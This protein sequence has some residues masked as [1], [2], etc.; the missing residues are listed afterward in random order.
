M[1]FSSISFIFMFLPAVIFAYFACPKR[2]LGARNLILLIFS[3]AFYFYGEPKFIIVMICSILLNYFFGLIIHIRQSTEKS[4]KVW[5]CISVII[6]LA[7]LFYFKYLSFAAENINIIFGGNLQF[8]KIIMPIGI[9]FFTFQAMSYVF[10][11]YKKTA[12]VQ[13][14]PVNMA[15]YISMFPQL[16]AGPVVRY[17]TVAAE[18]KHRTTTVE[19]FSHGIIRFIYGLSKKMIIANSMGFIADQV[20]GTRTHSLASATAWLGAAAYAF[21]IYYDFSGYSDM[22]IGLGKIFGFTFL[23]NFTFPYISKSITEFWRRWHISLSTWFRD[24]VYIPLG[25]NRVS[26]PRHILN[27]LIV[28]FLTGL[29]HGAAWNF[30]VWGLYFAVILI[31]EKTFI[32]KWLEKIWWPVSHFYAVILIIIGWIIFRSDD[33]NYA[34]GY[35]ARMFNLPSLFTQNGQAYYFLRQYWAEWLLAVVFSFPAGNFVT[36]IIGRHKDKAVCY[37]IRFCYIF[38]I[39]SVS[40]L[41]IVNSTFNPF[42]YFRF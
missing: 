29:W 6:N 40:V 11:V 35:I 22:A 7:I 17:E 33:L 32:L 8:E 30:I 25:G 2:F 19:K 20:F 13:K 9:S 26:F 15:L 28:W 31:L 34:L 12:S 18:I 24:Y 39:F 14:N 4:G 37:V 38:L 10:D 42:I 27:I 16:I 3:M 21:Q 23:E 1:V 41:Y 36:K 5:L